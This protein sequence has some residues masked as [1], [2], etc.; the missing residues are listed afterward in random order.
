MLV[1]GFVLKEICRFGVARRDSGAGAS[2]RVVADEISKLGEDGPV[3]EIVKDW[4]P[5]LE[6]DRL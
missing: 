3:Q 1:C 4:E 5:E 2:A 6:D